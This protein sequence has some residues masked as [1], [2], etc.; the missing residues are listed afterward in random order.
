MEPWHSPVFL[1]VSR[2][3]P[4]LPQAASTALSRRAPWILALGCVAPL[5]SCGEGNPG[6]DPPSDEFIF[7]NGVL[8]DPRVDSA[9]TGDAC[10]VDEDCGDGLACGGG[11]QCRPTTRWMFVTNAN[12]DR[13]YN[14]ASL[15][16]VNLDD[17]WAT[18]ARPEA[19][20]PAGADIDAGF[21]PGDAIGEDGPWPCRRVANL[22]QV[23]ECT[24]Q[25][26]VQAEATTHFGNFPGPAVAW[27]DQ[28]G[29]QA[30]KIFVP[31]RGDPSV[32]YMELRGG[33]DSPDSL[34]ISCDQNGADIGGRRCGSDYRLRFLR[35]DP[36]STRLS[37]EPFRIHIGEQGD[38][39]LAYVTHQGDPDLTLI[40]LDGLSTGGDGR[41]AIVH[42]TNVL[43]ADGSFPGG[44]G[45]A[46]RPCDPDNAPLSSDGC[47]RPLVYASLRWQRAIQSLT[48]VS[49]EPLEGSEQFCASPEELD[50]V[51]AIICEP[52]AEAVFRFSAGTLPVPGLSL[53]RP[54]LAGVAFSTS[55]DELYVVQS[56]PGAVLRIDTSIAPD[57]DPRNF[58]AAQVEVC[59]E[60]TSIRVYSDGENEYAL[61]TCYRSAEVYIIDL[62][63]FTV[64]GL[65]RAGIGPDAMAVDLAR[66]VV[67]VANSLDATIS[68][69]DMSRTR[70]SRFTEI[71]RIGLQEPY[72]Q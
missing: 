8:L 35:N 9:P 52:R 5:L 11:G 49:H 23:V 57:G 37:R 60:P 19:I 53:S 62:P 43:A 70:A 47:T 56:N 38:E 65:T 30:A 14:A 15:I 67:Y 26:F 29:E 39:P 64:A 7:P 54:I 28:P 63:S 25:P 21:E 69:I 41:P 4:R 72:S 46:E 50:Q 20:G 1:I 2:F 45:I 68:V 71:A 18:F 58:P 22:P 42:Q 32:T 36:D 31:V 16:P 27:Y 66:E 33:L 10:T 48:T 17:F 61:V 44:F 6:I 34:A 51:G 13:R 3:M 24:E 12:S 59:A 55:G 40:A